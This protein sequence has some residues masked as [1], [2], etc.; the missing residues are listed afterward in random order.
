MS[1]DYMDR[2]VELLL[3]DAFLLT[4]I[5]NIATLQDKDIRLPLV[6]AL[7]VANIDRIDATHDILVKA[8]KR[9]AQHI[10]NEVPRHGYIDVHDWHVIGNMITDMGAQEDRNKW[11]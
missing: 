9:A 2:P 8:E 6:I 4:E 7:G 10:V 3:M 5:E 11:N 1:F